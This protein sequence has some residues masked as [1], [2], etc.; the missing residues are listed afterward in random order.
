MTFTETILLWAG[1]MN[2]FDAICHS[3]GTVATGGFSTKNTS[4]AGYSAY[5]QYVIIF[6]MM[7]SGMNFSLHYFM[8]RGQFQKVGRNEEVRFYIWRL[9]SASV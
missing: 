5:A 4:I 1:D 6:F 2:L 7:I 9:F 3:F 8:L